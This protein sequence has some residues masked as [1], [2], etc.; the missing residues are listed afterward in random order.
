LPL[1]L[2]NERAGLSAAYYVESYLAMS[3]PA[4]LAGVLARTIGLIPATDVYA[5]ALIA[6]ALVAVAVDALVASHRPR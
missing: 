6:L 1:A 5:G 2:P 4:I 3:V